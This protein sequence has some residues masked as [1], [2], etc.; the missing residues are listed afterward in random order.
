MQIY[1]YENDEVKQNENLTFND[2]N[3]RLFCPYL[4][5]F[6]M[7]LFFGFWFTL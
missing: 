3:A 2:L 4:T 1:C 7:I 6:N 5:V